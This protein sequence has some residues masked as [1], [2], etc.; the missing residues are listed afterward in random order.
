[1][2]GSPPI[3]TTPPST[4]PPPSTRSNSAIRHIS[5]EKAYEKGFE[6]MRHREPDISKLRRF[7]D[8]EPAVDIKEMLG[9]VIGDL[10]NQKH[11]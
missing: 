1:M 6:D 8:F 9:K 10:Q 2:P 7:T 5:Y 11:H 4:R 3:S